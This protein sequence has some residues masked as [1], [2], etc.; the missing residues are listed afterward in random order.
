MDAI[1]LITGLL[2]GAALVVSGML[3]NASG[4]VGKRQQPPPPKP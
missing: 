4:I 3:L 2:L 1:Y